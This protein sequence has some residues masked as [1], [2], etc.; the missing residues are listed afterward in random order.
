MTSGIVVRLHRWLWSFIW[1][2]M[3]STAKAPG[4]RCLTDKRGASLM[5]QLVKNLCAMQETQE[6]RV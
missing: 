3:R 4:G 2:E 6:T 5:A 1:S